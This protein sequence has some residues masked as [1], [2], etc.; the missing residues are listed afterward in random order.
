[1]QMSKICEGVMMG[2]FTTLTL[3]DE[4]V[5]VLKIV[6]DKKVKICLA[7]NEYNHFEQIFKN[8][9]FLLK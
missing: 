5:I 9:D 2:T 4:Y 6:G 8:F 7:S 1:M 3:L